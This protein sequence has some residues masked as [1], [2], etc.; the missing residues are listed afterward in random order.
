MLVHLR[1]TRAHVS[2]EMTLEE[3]IVATP[4]LTSSDV[5]RLASLSVGESLEIDGEPAITVRRTP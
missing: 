5:A 4:S 2:S 3:F 1:V